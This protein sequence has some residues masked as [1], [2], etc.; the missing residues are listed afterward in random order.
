MS[1]RGSHQKSL[2]SVLV[3]L[4]SGTLLGTAGTAVALAP[5]DAST[6][7]LGVA[8]VGIGGLILLFLLP[9]FELYY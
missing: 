5:T 8:R 1:L 4:L 3:V 2:G 9:V 7:S 6:T